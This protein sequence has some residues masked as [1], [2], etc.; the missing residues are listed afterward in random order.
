MSKDTKITV[1]NHSFDANWE[2]L[3]KDL[4]TA[5]EPEII[6]S[7]GG[8][9]YWLVALPQMKESEAT[10]VRF[11]NHFSEASEA[12]LRAVKGNKIASL[13]SELLLL[14]MAL[15]C[16]HEQELTG[17]YDLKSASIVG[18]QFLELV[19]NE[20]HKSL[21]AMA[22]I[23]KLGGVK[24]GRGGLESQKGKY[25]TAFAACHIRGWK[26]PTKKE[27]RDELGVLPDADSTRDAD[28]ILREIGLGGLPPS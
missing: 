20:D 13:D 26:L 7:I 21:K 24:D 5:S 1:G 22:D 15:D 17:R 6:E 8:D 2:K 16:I 11:W 28:K 10:K 14:N 4:Q 25:L 23:I 27:I 12:R 3:K 18:V 19:K 9:F